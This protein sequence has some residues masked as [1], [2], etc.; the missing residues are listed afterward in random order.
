[1]AQV[2]RF[3]QIL[4]SRNAISNECAIHFAQRLGTLSTRFPDIC[5]TNVA[6][7]LL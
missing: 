2:T 4:K 5:T 3:T 6:S 1:L 7:C